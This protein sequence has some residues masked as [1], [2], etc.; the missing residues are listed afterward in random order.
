MSLMVLNIRASLGITIESQVAVEYTFDDLRRVPYR[1]H[2]Q[3]AN[4][5]ELEEWLVVVQEMHRDLVP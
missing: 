1:Y 3:D 4:D 5:I 2:H